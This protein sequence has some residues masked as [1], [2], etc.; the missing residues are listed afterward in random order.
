MLAHM[1]SEAKQRAVMIGLIL[2]SPVRMT[3]FV[4][5]PDVQFSM[6]RSIQANIW[7]AR[8]SISIYEAIIA[9]WED[10]ETFDPFLKTALEQHLLSSC[11]PNHK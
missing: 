9:A 4:H 3:G 5:S 8:H 2:Y 6:E 10:H 11:F 7:S 1:Q